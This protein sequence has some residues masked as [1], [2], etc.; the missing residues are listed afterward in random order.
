MVSVNSVDRSRIFEKSKYHI[1]LIPQSTRTFTRTNRCKSGVEGLSSSGLTT[2]L[3]NS[4][5]DA[6]RPY[7][8]EIWT[9]WERVIVPDVQF[10]RTHYTSHFTLSFYAIVSSYLHYRVCQ[11]RAYSIFVCTSCALGEAIESFFQSDEENIVLLSFFSPSL[12]VLWV[13]VEKAC[14]FENR[15]ESGYWML[16]CGLVNILESLIKS[17]ER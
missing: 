16:L 11:I 1:G 12:T 5:S 15:Q 4:S 2:L 7:I 17:V 14:K 13:N 3:W 8:W 6:N 9:A 10:L